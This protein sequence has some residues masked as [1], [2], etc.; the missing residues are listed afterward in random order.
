MDSYLW[1]DIKVCE[2]A[3]IPENAKKLE[4]RVE[5]LEKELESIKKL[6]S[7]LDRQ[8]IQQANL[9]LSIGVT[10]PKWSNIHKINEIEPKINIS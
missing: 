7:E 6:Y 4:E 1:Q 2:G 10:G 9:V 8:M 3:V 5:V